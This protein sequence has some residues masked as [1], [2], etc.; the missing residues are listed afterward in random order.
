MAAYLPG[1]LSAG[2]PPIVNERSRRLPTPTER[3]C[4]CAALDRGPE[5]PLVFR[6]R[7]RAA[8]AAPR[9]VPAID[10]AGHRASLAFRW[11]GG[12]C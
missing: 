10:F 1:T 11:P 8:A 2:S 9:E 12:A 3:G 4:R 6:P 7:P 5:R